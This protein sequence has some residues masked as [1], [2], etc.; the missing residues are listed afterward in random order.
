V[1]DR[2]IFRVCA[3]NRVD[4]RE[5]TD[6]ESS[7]EGRDTLYTGI[8]VCCVTCVELVAVADPLEAVFGDV[9]ESN[10][11]VVAGNTVN[12]LDADLLETSEEVLQVHDEPAGLRVSR[13]IVPTSATS[14]GFLMSC[15][16]RS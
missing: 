10:K 13:E 11:V 5:L 4:C 2:D 12:R 15:D 16:L 1:N 9:V 7:D 14:I 8:A 3:C 6:T